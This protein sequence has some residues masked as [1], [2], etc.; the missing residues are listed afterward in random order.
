V[1]LLAVLLIIVA[2]FVV[3]GRVRDS[4]VLRR[5]PDV[6]AERLNDTDRAAVERAVDR[7][8]S[9]RRGGAV[10]G[11]VAFAV[12]SLLWGRTL[13]I[14]FVAVL[15]GATAGVAIAEWRVA[16]PASGPLRTAR[17]TRR[18][19]S[20]VIGRLPLLLVMISVLGAIGAAL[21]WALMRPGVSGEWTERVGDR[22]FSTTVPD[23]ASTNLGWVISTAAVTLALCAAALIT[24]RPASQSLPESADLALRQAGVRSA[25][26]CAIT[27]AAAQAAVL[28]YSLPNVAF[29]AAGPQ[30]HA[31]SVGRS[32]FLV[33]AVFMAWL[34]A[35]GLVRYVLHPVRR[36]ARIAVSA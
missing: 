26:G 35:T 6:L 2:A 28:L 27:L 5:L 33:G 3:G 30:S 23:R 17:I 15:A 7:L 19:L 21:A 22:V 20:G 13:T 25:L 24:R 31:Q 34:A 18:T 32:A 1:A 4:A 8:A 14:N 9:F 10:I 12:P 11:A 36:P 16:A 29:G